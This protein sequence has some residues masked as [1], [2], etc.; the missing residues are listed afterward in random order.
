MALPNKLYMFNVF[1]NGTSYLGKAEALSMPKLTRKTEDYQ[2]AGMVV[3]AA[4]D[5]GFESGALNMELTLG[6]LE[7]ELLATWGEKIDGVQLRFAGSYLDDA[8][9]EPIALEIQTRGRLSE[10]DFGEA[11]QG[12]NTSHK[13]SMKNTYVKIAI[14]GREEFELDALNLLYNVRGKDVLAKHRKNMGL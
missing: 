1:I 14:N 2:G 13:Y 6:G 11:K 8:T 10:L 9:N 12:D 3:S 5:L 7:S 4:V